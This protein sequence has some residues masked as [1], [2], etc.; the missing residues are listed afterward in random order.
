MRETED[1]EVARGG[2]AAA[3]DGGDGLYLGGGHVA[4]RSG[5]WLGWLGFGG[6]GVSC[7][8]SG[9]ES[10]D[11]DEYDNGEQ[12]AVGGGA[13]GLVCGGVENCVANGGLHRLEKE[14]VE[15]E[16]G[17]SILTWRKEFKIHELHIYNFRI[18]Y[19]LL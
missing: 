17:L 5:D 2:A 12:G 15:K 4:G 1:E 9:S 16:T 10:E 19:I 14:A 11:E 7:G 3:E 8:E 6:G 18:Y 13:P